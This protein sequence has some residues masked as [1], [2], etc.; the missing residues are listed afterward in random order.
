[1]VIGWLQAVGHDGRYFFHKD[2]SEQLTDQIPML[3]RDGT[4]PAHEVALWTFARLALPLP[5]LAVVCFALK[6]RVARLG[7]ACQYGEQ[8][9][10]ARLVFDTCAI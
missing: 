4:E 2:V 3:T 8:F 7:P 9:V 6:I 10:I 1:M 5:L